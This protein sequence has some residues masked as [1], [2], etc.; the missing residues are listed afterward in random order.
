MSRV[1]ICALALL[2]CLTAPMQ[3]S[4]AETDGVQQTM[5]EFFVNLRL[6]LKDVA[7]QRTGASHSS[8]LKQRTARR[9]QV[10][11]ALYAID[12]QAALLS[13]HA[14]TDDE[15]TGFLAASLAR[16]ATAAAYRLD[17]GDDKNWQRHLFKMV[18]LCVACH[19]RHASG[20]LP[21]GSDFLSDDILR[22]L[23]LASQAELLTATRRFR[24]AFNV[25]REVIDRKLAQWVARPDVKVGA[26]Q[27]HEFFRPLISALVIAT[28]LLNDFDAARD[29]L[30]SV[31]DNSNVP[32]YLHD[33]VAHFA[34]TLPALRRELRDTD[35][36]RVESIEAL[37][38]PI[39]ELERQVTAGGTL[40]DVVASALLYRL[41]D[42]AQLKGQDRA[43]ALYLVGVVE[44]RLQARKLPPG[45]RAW[46]PQTELFLELA[47]LA[48]P[49]SDTA[50]DS[51]VL[52]E[53][54]VQAAFPGS[55]PAEV[56]THL[57]MLKA[58]SGAP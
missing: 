49:D 2:V 52:L 25:W 46:L 41:I 4:N 34:R 19:S 40:R 13:G 9:A 10:R 38:R 57:E 33:T 24:A 11:D 32:V 37:L 30:I 50:R 47:I 12:D 15:L 35:S 53:Q 39:P 5:R 22:T 44:R 6:L 45:Q 54:V 26:P 21:Q 16:M 7:A 42:G 48:A 51:Y 14:R 3:S 18:D 31:R 1:A 20:G 17:T 29:L 27:A 36:Q 28:R 23:P 58:T 43:R 56:S 55:M 8:T